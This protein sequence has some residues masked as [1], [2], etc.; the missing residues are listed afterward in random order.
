[1]TDKSKEN[2][3]VNSLV[4]NILKNIIMAN[5]HVIK[6]G[7]SSFFDY[8]DVESCEKKQNMEWIFNFYFN[9]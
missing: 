5:N 6:F 2:I 3:K 8:Y 9:L 1:M 4:E 7:D